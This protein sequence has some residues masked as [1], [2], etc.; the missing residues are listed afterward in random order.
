MKLTRENGLKN[1]LD[2][3]LNSDITIYYNPDK[4]ELIVY[5]D[6]KAK[7]TAQTIKSLALDYISKSDLYSAYERITVYS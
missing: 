7:H 6:E 4:F 3:K 1:N 2:S 5:I